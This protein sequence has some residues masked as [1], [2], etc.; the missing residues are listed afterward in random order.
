MDRKIRWIQG[1]VWMPLGLF[2]GVINLVQRL[3]TAVPN[4][5]WHEGP[6]TWKTIFP[7]TRGQGMVS[8]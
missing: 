8:G 3:T 6:V 7:W 4:L 2:K 1:L 5:F